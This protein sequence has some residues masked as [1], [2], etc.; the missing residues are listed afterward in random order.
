MQVACEAKSFYSMDRDILLD[1]LGA[2]SN[3]EYEVDAVTGAIVDTDI[4]RI[5]AS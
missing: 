5:S 3:Y 2:D 4:E 1:R